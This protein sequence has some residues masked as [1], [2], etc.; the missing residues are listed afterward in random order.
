MPKIGNEYWSGRAEKRMNRYERDAE[1]VIR[2]VDA[3]YRRAQKSVADEVRVLFDRFGRRFNL[4]PEETKAILERNESVE[5]LEALKDYALSSGDIAAMAR[6]SAP[7]FR[8]RISVLHA[9]EERA[10]Q[11]VSAARGVEMAR[12]TD[13][14]VEVAKDSYLRTCFDTQRIEGYGR[15]VRRLASPVNLPD[16]VARIPRSIY[17]TR[18]WDDDVLMDDIQQMDIEAYEGIPR[19]ETYSRDRRLEEMLSARWSGMNYSERIW[20]NGETIAKR[21][22]QDLAF[23]ILAGHDINQIIDQ[24]AHDFDIARWQASRLIRTEYTYI[25]NATQL[26]AYRDMDMPYYQFIATLDMKTSEVCQ[27]HDGRI[28]PV[29]K[30]EIGFNMPPLHP[31]CRSTTV[32][33]LKPEK[34]KDDT[35]IAINP[36]TGAYERLPGDMS[37]KE[38]LAKYV[39]P[40]AT[41]AGMRRVKDLVAADKNRR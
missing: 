7:S 4:N 2:V 34:V 21:V 22:Q 37:Y 5:V 9:M 28:Y 11:A 26:Q 29:N 16:K 40:R 31:W 32:G 19:A 1:E 38:W 13:H 24:L 3:A 27:Y 36:V 15:P 39:Y 6:I 35:R 30:A 25:A 20:R 10:Y 12:T 33:V 17:D 23:G 14:L 8:H 18:R 41:E